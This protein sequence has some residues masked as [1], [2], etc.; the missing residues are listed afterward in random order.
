MRMLLLLAF[1]VAG[2]AADY[3]PEADAPAVTPKLLFV[4]RSGGAGDQWFNQVQIKGGVVSAADDSGAFGL[5][6]TVG[7]DD[8][9]KATVVGNRAAIGK[10]QRQLPNG[11]KIGPVTYGYR[12]VDPNLQ[13]PFM[14]GPGWK[15]WGWNL[16]QA[17]SAKCRYAPLMADARIRHALLTPIGSIVA[18]ATT[19]G[20]NTSLRANPHDI[21]L[22]LEPAIS[23]SITGGGGGGTSSWVYE[24]SQEGKYQRVLVCRGFVQAGAFD[25]WGR[26]LV[27]GRGVI[28]KPM[29]NAFPY[30]DGGGLLMCDRE[31]QKALFSTHFG[32]EKAGE[33]ESNLWA[34]AVDSASGIAAVAG[35]V[36]GGKLTPLE[37]VQADDGGG[38]DGFLAVFR[39]W[40][41]LPDK[42]MP[43]R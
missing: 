13:L 35:Y 40:P 22:T 25:A 27:V 12:Q 16:E 30:P 38:T 41:A 4:S 15:L 9:I 11:G 28:A 29:S 39:L 7:K 33:T 1:T 34:V 2:N 20:G 19:D 10:V 14:D 6:V 21:D 18:F 24:I 17:K 5:K 42:K 31:W 36:R 32:M 37:G 43:R 23:N 8:T 3:L 26:M